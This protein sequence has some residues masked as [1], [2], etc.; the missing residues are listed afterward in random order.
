MAHIGWHVYC[1]KVKLRV[2]GA[3]NVRLFTYLFVWGH[4]WGGGADIT[5]K[6]TCEEKNT[7]IVRV[8]SYQTDEI[9]N[10]Y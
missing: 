2:D 10:S 5:Y 1:K 8:K 7:L 3:I 4:Y 6:V 9:V